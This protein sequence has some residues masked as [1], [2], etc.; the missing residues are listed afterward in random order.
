MFSFVSRRRKH[1]KKGADKKASDS[2]DGLKKKFKADKKIKNVV[3][4]SGEK[5]PKKKKKA[6]NKNVNKTD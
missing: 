5:K 3:A 4:K 2:S 6:N 1:G